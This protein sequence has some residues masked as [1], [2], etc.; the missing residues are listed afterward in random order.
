M[1]MP[2]GGDEMRL[3]SIV[4][5]VVWFTAAYYGLGIFAEGPV[6]R[7]IMGIVATVGFLL[8]EQRV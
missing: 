2:Y 6:G 8:V 4:L 1:G 5:A 3:T 7:Y